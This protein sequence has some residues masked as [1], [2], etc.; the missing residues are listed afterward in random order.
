MKKSLLLAVVML[1]A[2]ALSAQNEVVIL[3]H[4]GTLSNYSGTTALSQALAAAVSG[5]IVTVSSGNFSITSIP[6]GVTVRGAGFEEDIVAGGILPT[7]VSYSGSGN[8]TINNRAFVEGIK[9]TSNVKVCDSVKLSKCYFYNYLYPYRS[10][11]NGYDSY[12]AKKLEIVNCYIGTIQN[13]N[14][15]NSIITNSIIGNYGASGANSSGG[16]NQVNNSIIGE[17]NYSLL[18]AENNRD[19]FTGCILMTNTNCSS[20]RKQ[21][22]CYNCI[23]LTRQSSYCNAGAPFFNDNSQPAINYVQFLNLTQ[24]QQDS[25]LALQSTQMSQQHHNYNA[26]TFGELFETLTSVT[27]AQFTDYSLT[28]VF[29]TLAIQY[30]IGVYK[31]MAPYTPFVNR[32]HYIRTT[33]SPRTTADGQLSIDIQVVTN[34]D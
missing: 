18:N 19:I 3:S 15:K 2:G 11:T 24:A 31:G 6:A 14:M 9:F 21:D 12:D 23:G 26:N 33:V 16:G 25:V 34:E 10:N 13:N 22:N 5:D 4:N 1:F 32:P 29:D 30:N 8:I 17:I 7:I 20:T 27:A 28:P